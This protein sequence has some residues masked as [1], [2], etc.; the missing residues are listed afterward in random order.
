MKRR[1]GRWNS[2]YVALCRPVCSVSVLEQAEELAWQAVAGRLWDIERALKGRLVGKDESC[3]LRDDGFAF[4]RVTLGHALFQCLKS[5][6]S[7]RQEFHR[8][9][10]QER[11]FYSF[12]YV[13]L[14][15]LENTDTTILRVLCEGTIHYRCW[16]GETS[17]SLRHKIIHKRTVK[18]SREHR[19]DD[20]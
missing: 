5:W 17:H 16:A 6:H 4:T 8:A 3:F 7:T 19:Y 11:T 14:D 18:L 10:K 15:C 12:L 20:Y 9:Q 1:S 13:P 2:L